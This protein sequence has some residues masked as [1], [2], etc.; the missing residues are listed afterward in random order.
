[1]RQGK[2][3][4]AYAF[5]GCPLAWIFAQASRRPTVRLNTGRAG[6]ASGS[7]QK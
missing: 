6:V 2:Y 1:M 4:C 5:L 3:R 7:R